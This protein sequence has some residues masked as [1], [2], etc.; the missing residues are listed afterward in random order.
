[1]IPSRTLGCVVTAICFLA[2]GIIGTCLGL[3][4]GSSAAPSQRISEEWV[5]GS[6]LLIQGGDFLVVAIKTVTG[7]LLGAFGGLSA[8]PIGLNLVR[9]RA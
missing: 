8:A 4:S 1:M 3:W 9:R 7:G 6:N 5:P 2:G